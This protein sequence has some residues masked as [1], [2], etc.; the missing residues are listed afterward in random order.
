MKINY[1]LLLL[2]AFIFSCKTEDKKPEIKTISTEDVSTID[3]LKLRLNNGEKWIVNEETHLGMK[4]ID[5]ILKN[6]TFSEL[7]IVG[8]ALSKQTSYIIKNCDMKGVAH[9][10]LHVV[11]VP[12]LEEISNLKEV[13][14]SSETEVSINKLKGLISKYYKYFDL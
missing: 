14:N 9:D 3:S 13:K 11:L 12:I 1:S 6:R 8:D 10:Q 7:K 2:I 5:S 4:R